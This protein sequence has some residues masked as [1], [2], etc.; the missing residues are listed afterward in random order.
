[1]R[2]RYIYASVC[3]CVRTKKKI[4]SY[5]CRCGGGGVKPLTFK[6]FYFII[7]QTQCVLL[8]YIL[9]MCTACAAAVRFDITTHTSRVDTKKK[10]IF[11]LIYIL[12]CARRRSSYFCECTRSGFSLPFV[13]M[14]G[15]RCASI[16]SGDIWTALV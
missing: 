14:I 16:I 10:T 5:S 8:F 2:S 11:V 15:L 1:M 4:S 9:Y 12:K 6:F 13:L 3:V 7:S